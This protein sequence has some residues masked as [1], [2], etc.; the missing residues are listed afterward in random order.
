MILTRG[1]RETKLAKSQ[2]LT[3]KQITVDVSDSSK[4]PQRNLC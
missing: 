4:K 1:W 3:E 2:P